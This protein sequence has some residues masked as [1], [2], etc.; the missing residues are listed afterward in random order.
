[1]GKKFVANGPVTGAKQ[2]GKSPAPPNKMGTMADRQA[3]K[4]GP[5]FDK[6]SQPSKKRPPQ[7][8]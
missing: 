5:I 3:V 7:K 6:G 1:M 2:Q 8:L 4:Q